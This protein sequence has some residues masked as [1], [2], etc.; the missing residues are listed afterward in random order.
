LIQ[1][2]L[3]TNAAQ[4]VDAWGPVPALMLRKAGHYRHQLLLRSDERSPLHQSIDLLLNWLDAAPTN[5][6]VRWSLDV[7][8]VSL[9]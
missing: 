8:P 1:Q 3:E 5:H 4:G 6:K 2:F 9:D 7:D